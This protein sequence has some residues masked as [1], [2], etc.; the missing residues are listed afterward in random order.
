MAALPVFIDWNTPHQ[1]VVLMSH[2]RRMTQTPI[3]IKTCG[4]LACR[5][6]CT[7]ALDSQSLA[8]AASRAREN[9]ERIDDGVILWIWLHPASGRSGRQPRTGAAAPRRDRRSG[10]PHQWHQKRSF[11]LS[12][13]RR[14]ATAAG[15]RRRATGASAHATRCVYQWGLGRKF[16]TFSELGVWPT[17]VGCAAK[18]SGFLWIRVK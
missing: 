2:R 10:K 11:C 1:L 4:P 6:S 3:I 13:R 8:D 7:C 15:N 17:C 5:V 18:I 12:S 9:G 16:P 14:A